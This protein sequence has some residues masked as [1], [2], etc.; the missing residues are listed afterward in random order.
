[1]NECNFGESVVTRRNRN[2][3]TINCASANSATKNTTRN[4][5]GLNPRL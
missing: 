3:Q 1:M 5:P 2:I 4:G